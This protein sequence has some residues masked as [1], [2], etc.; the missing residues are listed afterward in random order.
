MEP[1]KTLGWG[2][3]TVLVGAGIGMGAF[4]AAFLRF[5]GHIGPLLRRW[6]PS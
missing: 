2:M 6:L 4:G 1:L 3:R 5:G